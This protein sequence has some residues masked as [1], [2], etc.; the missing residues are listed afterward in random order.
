MKTHEEIGDRKRE[1]K[2][3]EDFYPAARS[4]GPGWV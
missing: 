1:K 3:N 4:S 2:S